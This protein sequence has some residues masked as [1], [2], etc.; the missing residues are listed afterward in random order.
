MNNHVQSYKFIWVIDQFGSPSKTLKNYNNDIITA[1]GFDLEFWDIRALNKTWHKKNPNFVYDDDGLFIIQFSDIDTIK[2]EVNRVTAN[3]VKVAFLLSGKIGFWNKAFIKLLETK[4][5]PYF[6]RRNRTSFFQGDFGSTSAKKILGYTPK[7][8]INAVFSWLMNHPLVTLGING[9]KLIFAGTKYDLEQINYPYQPNQVIYTHTKDFDQLLVM[10]NQ[11]V[12]YRDAIVFIDQFIP[13]HSE[14][15]NLGIDPTLFYSTIYEFLKFLSVKKNKRVFFAAHPVS[16]ME[17]MKKYIPEELLIFGKTTELVR[18]CYC[19][20]SFNSSAIMIAL[21]ANRPFVLLRFDQIIPKSF[22]DITNHLEDLFKTKSIDI[23]TPYTIEQIDTILAE[24]QTNR[25]H[26]FN[27]YVKH[28]G[29]L[30]QPEFKTICDEI[31]H[32]LNTSHS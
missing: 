25:E 23:G 32:Y 28:T 19:A 7:R 2:K 20:I 4:N 15:K 12:E 30:E 10:Q 1:N 24:Q 22:A 16:D 18:N 8:I 17:L 21:I 3:G 13:F 9:P 5:I 6:V 11:A 29:T 27:D 26:L 14:T 31:I